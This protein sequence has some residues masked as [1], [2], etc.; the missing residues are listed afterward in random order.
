LKVKSGQYL[1]IWEQVWEWDTNRIWKFKGI[2]LKV[3]KPQHPDWTFT[4]RWNVAG[5]FVE[6]IYPLSFA[7]FEKVIL[8][9]EYKTRRSKLYYLRDKVWKWAKMKS[10]ID[11]E[12]KWV[13]LWKMALDSVVSLESKSQVVVE[14]NFVVDSDSNN[15]DVVV[16]DDVSK[17]AE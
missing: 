14:E 1:E 9:D 16:S 13:D 3:K 11:S 4:I 8:L 15:A 12:M 2:V 10:N 17:I 5:V 6:R 7:K